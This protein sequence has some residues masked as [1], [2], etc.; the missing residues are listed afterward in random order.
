[1]LIR[2]SVVLLPLYHPIRLAEDLAVLDLIAAGA[3]PA[4][5][6]RRLPARGVRAVRPQHQAP[7]VADGG[8]AWRC[9]SRRGPVSRSSGAATRC[10]SC[11]APHRFPG[12]RS[13]W[14]ARRPRRPSAPHASPT[15]SSLWCRSSTTSTSRSS[16][17]LGKPVP[18]PRR[19]G[20]GGGMFFHIAED[21][22]RAWAQIAPHAMHETNDY[23]EWAKGHA[24]LALHGVRQFRR[25]PQER[26]VRDRHP[27][28]RRRPHSRARRR[29]VQA[30]DGRTR[31]RARVG[32]APPVRV[33][34]LAALGASRA[35][36]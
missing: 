4:D 36:A 14:A 28:R 30:V 15:T 23:A 27:R 5:G 8:R 35:P 11:P 3:P 19:G 18:E 22:D 9:S 6:G 34:G 25:A 17:T 10:A 29:G 12:P 31:S 1:M 2:M 33:E 20:R 26:D 7:A 16:P 24:R 13:R 32:V 21:P